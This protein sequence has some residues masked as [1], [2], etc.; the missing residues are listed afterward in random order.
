[1]KLWQIVDAVHGAFGQRFQIPASRVLRLVSQAQRMAFGRD[2]R[3]FEKKAAISPADG[4]TTYPFPPDCRAVKEILSDGDFWVDDFVRDIAAR[5]A[6]PPYLEIAYYRQ[7][8]DL[9][10][11]GAEYM[12]ENFRNGTDA[13]KEALFSSADEA[14]VLVPLEWR[15]QVLSQLAMAF[16]DTENY[17]DKTP[18]AVAEQFL[19]EFWEA[20]DRRPNDRKV[21]LSVGAW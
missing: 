13:H 2:C 18:Q 10:C 5:S 16:C 4:G 7:P 17:G 20:M 6:A 19:R 8:E 9:T 21:V 11:E 14:K 12:D 1:M 3:A 15:W